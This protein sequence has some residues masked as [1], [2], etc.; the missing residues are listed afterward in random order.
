VRLSSYLAV[1]LLVDVSLPGD[2]RYL[3]SCRLAPT[4]PVMW[5]SLEDAS[6]ITWI[7]WHSATQVNTFI[8]LNYH[9]GSGPPLKTYA[10]NRL[11]LGT[12]VL[13]GE[14]D[15]CNVQCWYLHAALVG[16]TCDGVFVGRRNHRKAYPLEGVSVRRL[17]RRVA[18]S[19]ASPNMA[20]NADT[21]PTSVPILEYSIGA[22]LTPQPHTSRIVYLQ[23]ILNFGHS[24]EATKGEIPKADTIL[25]SI[26]SAYSHR[27]PV[28][29]RL[30]CQ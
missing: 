15:E 21:P 13:F 27:V 28:Q 18:T 11:A 14:R 23:S 30:Y 25:L 22:P 5:Q 8:T 12:F 7:T 2:F 10:C 29:R 9:R 4:S 19:L 3:C 6:H 20:R 17:N 16:I 1:S 26:L 24:L